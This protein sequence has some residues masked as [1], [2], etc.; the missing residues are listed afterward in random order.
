M[1][2]LRCT[3]TNKLKDM[4]KFKESVKVIGVEAIAGSILILSTDEQ[5]KRGLG[6]QVVVDNDNTVVQ[7]KLLELDKIT[8][9]NAF[10]EINSKQ[11]S[12]NYLQLLFRKLKDEQVEKINT[13]LG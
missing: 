7:D 1:Y 6:L 2:L 8:T 3:E 4:K 5:I 11:Q 9:F 12:D 10:K 13:L